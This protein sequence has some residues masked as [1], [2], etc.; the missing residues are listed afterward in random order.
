MNIQDLKKETANR[1]SRILGYYF[2][3]ACCRFPRFV[4]WV[5]KEHRNGT[6]PIQN[7]L[8]LVCRY[9]RAENLVAA[10]DMADSQAGGWDCPICGS[11]WLDLCEEKGNLNYAHRFVLDQDRRRDALMSQGV[12]T[13][14]LT[15]SDFDSIEEWE[16]FMTGHSESPNNALQPTCEDARG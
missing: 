8:I 9:Y 14:V 10:V 1:S 12:P 5:T 13:T 7:N 15:T 3:K 11:K 2:E 16:R 4:Y 6:D